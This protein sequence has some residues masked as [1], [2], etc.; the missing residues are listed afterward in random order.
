MA[1][2]ASASPIICTYARSVHGLGAGVISLLLECTAHR[3]LA[4]AEITF[5]FWN[6]FASQCLWLC[7]ITPQLVQ[8]MFY[9]PC[10][11]A[12]PFFLRYVLTISQPT[13]RHE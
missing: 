11:V 10:V 1:Y 12:A 2:E 9:L 7:A 4:T 13:Y 3:D 5:S 8:L 6:K